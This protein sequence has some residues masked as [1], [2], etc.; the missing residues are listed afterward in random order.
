MTEEKKLRILDATHGIQIHL[1]QEVAYEKDK[2][3]RKVELRDV[4]GNLQYMRN[5]GIGLMGILGRLDT[6]NYTLKD[7]KTWTKLRDK[8]K[9]GYF[10]DSD[11]VELTLDEA[12]FL[13]DFLL[14]VQTKEAQTHPLQEFEIRTLVGISE[15]F[16]E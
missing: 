1:T 2:K 15:Q 5:D 12:K 4:E 14:N 3:G 10:Q 9:E 16:A 6:R 8:L 7:L 13:K 11:V